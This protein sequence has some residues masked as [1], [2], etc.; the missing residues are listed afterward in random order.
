MLTVANLLAAHGPNG[1]T[2][3][4]IVV[5]VCAVSTEQV[6]QVRRED[7]SERRKMLKVGCYDGTTALGIVCWR[8]QYFGMFRSF[9]QAKKQLEL[10]G[11]LVLKENMLNFGDSKQTTVRTVMAPII[12]VTPADIQ[13]ARLA[14]FPV[15]LP[16]LAVRNSPQKKRVSLTGRIQRVSIK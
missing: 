11:D 8:E 5:A 1:Q 14:M 12:A 16:I 7:R 6:Y 4:Q 10:S 9:A 13:R 2:N 3:G 15:V